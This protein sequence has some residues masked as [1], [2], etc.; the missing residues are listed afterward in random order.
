MLGYVPRAASLPVVALSAFHELWYT[1]YS[2]R[3][4]N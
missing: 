3:R 4:S 1:V 2:A